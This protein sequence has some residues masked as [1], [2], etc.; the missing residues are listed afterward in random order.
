MATENECALAGKLEPECFHKHLEAK[1]VGVV[2]LQMAARKARD[3][4]HVSQTLRDGGELI[5]YLGSELLVGN[6]DVHT[7]PFV[8]A[9]KCLHVFRL[10]LK[11]NVVE[12]GELAIDGGGVAVSEHAS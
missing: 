10:S 11:T 9:Q 8:T 7:L 12:T 1:V 3:R 4:I 5:Y 6:G 2:T